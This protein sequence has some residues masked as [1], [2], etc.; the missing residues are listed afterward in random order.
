MAA[1]RM[2]HNHL[3]IQVLDWHKVGAYR[4]CGLQIH[5]DG[6][7][8]A[9]VEYD[10]G[11]PYWGW[12]HSND[13]MSTIGAVVLFEL[14][15]LG[16]KYRLYVEKLK[17]F[18]ADTEKTAEDILI[19]FLDELKSL[20]LL[21]ASGQ[22]LMTEVKAEAG[23]RGFANSTDIVRSEHFVTVQCGI[24]GLVRD[25]SDKALVVRWAVSMEE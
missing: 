13:D 17:A 23:R 2:Q 5:R 8:R 22:T 7:I 16:S 20:E 1:T 25:E 3:Y 4:I 12:I 6:S 19:A 9:Q 24:S 10:N 21:G 18:K 14:A 15:N 11:K